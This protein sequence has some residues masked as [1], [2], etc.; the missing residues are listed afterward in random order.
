MY[1]IIR[2][3]KSDG[4]LTEIATTPYLVY[5]DMMVS[6]FKTLQPEYFNYYREPIS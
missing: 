2:Q 5:A 4:L 1:R 6:Q 3:R